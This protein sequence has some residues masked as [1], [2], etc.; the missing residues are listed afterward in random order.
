MGNEGDYLRN[1]HKFDKW[2]K[3]NAILCSILRLDCWPWSWL[4]L[5]LPDQTMGRQKWSH[6]IEIRAQRCQVAL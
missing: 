2:L 3:A 6:R 1:L 5:I 4:V